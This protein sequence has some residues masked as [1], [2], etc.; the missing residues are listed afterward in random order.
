MSDDMSLDGAV[1]VLNDNWH[2]DGRWQAK[3]GGAES[4]PNRLSRFEA[5]ATAREWLRRNAEFDAV[6]RAR[7]AVG[8]ATRAMAE[9]VRIAFDASTQRHKLWDEVFVALAIKERLVEAFLTE[10]EDKP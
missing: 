8:P 5:V 9:D 6:C 10:V 4:G 2:R 1:K 3:D 7:P